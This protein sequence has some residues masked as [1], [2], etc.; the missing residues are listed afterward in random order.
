L[1]HETIERHARGE[2]VWEEAAIDRHVRAHMENALSPEHEDPHSRPTVEAPIFHTPLPADVSRETP[3]AMVAPI[4]MP[5]T[6]APSLPR[7]L[8]T[9]LVLIV[10]M[11]VSA[12][13]VIGFLY[14]RRT[15]RR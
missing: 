2:A 6:P 7:A 15:S 3:S 1:G 10:V 4:L 8:V 9:A 5:A 13:G 11:L 14:G 12:A